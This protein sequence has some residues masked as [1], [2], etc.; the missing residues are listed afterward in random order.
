LQTNTTILSI[1]CNRI[2]LVYEGVAERRIRLVVRLGIIYNIFI[3]DKEK[4]VKNEE[5]KKKQQKKQTPQEGKQLSGKIVVWIHT[6]SSQ[7]T[8]SDHLTNSIIHLLI[9]Y[10]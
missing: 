2:I 5:R 8:S 10:S 9:L 7:D 3:M 1:H 6:L 4:Y